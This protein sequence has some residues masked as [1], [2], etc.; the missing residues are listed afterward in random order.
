[1]SISAI[2]IAVSIAVSWRP[3]TRRSM[4]T[5]FVEAS[6]SGS[7]ANGA[8]ARTNP[9]TKWS[10]GLHLERRRLP[11]SGRRRS[12]RREGR[13]AAGEVVEPGDEP[14]VIVPPASREAEVA[15]AERTGERDLAHVRRRDRRGERRGLERDKRAC[16]LAALK[17]DPFRL[18]SLGR[19]PASLVDQQDRGIH[20]PVRERLQA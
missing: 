10:G 3:A 18:V 9:R 12:G 14:R 19:P 1:M 15:V 5:S 2:S 13:H 16:D 11:G 7:D 17:L 6:T 20:D 4:P 8:A